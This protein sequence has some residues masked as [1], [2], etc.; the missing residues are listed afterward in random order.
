M[1]FLATIFSLFSE[2]VVLKDIVARTIDEEAEELGLSMDLQ[3]LSH[4]TL[5]KSSDLYGF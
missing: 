1:Y 2:S 5:D 4:V 3:L